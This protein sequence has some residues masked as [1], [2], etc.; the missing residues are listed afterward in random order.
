LNAGTTA[1]TTTDG[2]S[3]AS[4][5]V[6]G[7]VDV[8]A[9]LDVNAGADGSFFGLFDKTTQVNLLSKKFELFKVRIILFT[10]C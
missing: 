4:A 7:C 3:S 1:N 2:D 6:D 5:S 10:E 8:G 9:E